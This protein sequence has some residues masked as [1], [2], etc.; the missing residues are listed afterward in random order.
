LARHYKAFEPFGHG[1]QTI[2][3]QRVAI[4]PSKLFLADQPGLLENSKVPGN[5]W[6]TDVEIAS[7]HVHRLRTIAQDLENATAGW[8]G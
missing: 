5:G 1:L 2:G 3:M 8:I 7:E 6:P 4:F